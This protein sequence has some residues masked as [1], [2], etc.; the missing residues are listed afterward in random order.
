MPFLARLT[1]VGIAVTLSAFTL[2]AGPFRG[3]PAMASEF[4]NGELQLEFDTGRAAVSD[5]VVPLAHSRVPL[6]NEH[7]LEGFRQAAAR[8]QRIVETGGWERIPP[9][10][11]LSLG[12]VGPR[13]AVLRRRLAATGDLTQQGGIVSVFDSF[14]ADAVRHFQRR[15][16]LPAHGIVDK[17]TLA[18]LNVPAE[19][20]LA[21]IHLNYERMRSLAGNKLPERFVLVNIP[22][23][24]LEAVENGEVRQRHRVVVGKPEFQTPVLRASIVE[25]NFY[26]YW[27]VPESIAKRDIIPQIRKQGLSYL[28]KTRTRVLEDWGGREVDPATI[29]W[30]SPDAERYKFRQ[31]PGRKNALGVLRI[32]MPNKEAVYLHDTPLKRLFGRETRAYSAGCVRVSN[33]LGLAEW[34]LEPVGDWDRQ[35]IKSVIAGNAREDAKLSKRVPV[36]FAYFTAWV[37]PDG[38]TSFREDIYG[39]DEID[40]AAFAARNADS[41]PTPSDAG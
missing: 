40:R 31:D 19:E 8:Y 2:A 22:A 18:A 34:L 21:K 25:L 7:A 23:S 1:R 4:G 11:D 27:H 12:A 30:H 29:D 37:K 5:A 38:T 24:E 20:R 3:L 35:R 26:P 39:R 36:Y 28:E 6:L 33:I 14:V 17:R 10:P 9:G 13:V 15:H 41:P 32:N 16:G